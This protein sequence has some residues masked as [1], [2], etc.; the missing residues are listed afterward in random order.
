M[1]YSNIYIILKDITCIDYSHHNIEEDPLI[2]RFTYRICSMVED[3]L[4]RDMFDRDV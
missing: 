2:K 1:I 4:D 3:Y